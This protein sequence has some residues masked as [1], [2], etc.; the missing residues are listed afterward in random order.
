[1]EDVVDVY[2]A[3]DE[4]AVAMELAALVVVCVAAVEVGWL[5]EVVATTLLTSVVEA[6]TFVGVPSDGVAEQVAV[7]PTVKERRPSA[8]RG[9]AV[10]AGRVP[11]YAL[12]L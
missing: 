9:S 6:A 4:D 2:W 11:T 12:K 10:P 7:N 5:E 3:C 1:M 8:A